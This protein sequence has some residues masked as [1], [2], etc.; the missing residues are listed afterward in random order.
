MSNWCLQVTIGIFTTTSSCSLCSRPTQRWSYVCFHALLVQVPQRQCLP[1]PA[2]RVVPG[3]GTNLCQITH[4][5]IAHIFCVSIISQIP[6][7]LSSGRNGWHGK[8]TSHISLT[9]TD[10]P[11]SLAGHVAGSLPSYTRGERRK[12]EVATHRCE[13]VGE[14]LARSRSEVC[15]C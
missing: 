8:E 5:A 12:E 3:C 9:M 15:M 14:H 4:V 2:S 6:L 1:Q 7:R 13:V 10:P 11:C